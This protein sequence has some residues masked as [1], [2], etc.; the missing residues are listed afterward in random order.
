M[1]SARAFSLAREARRQFRSK[2]VRIW[3]NKC[4]NIK[5]SEILPIDSA[6]RSAAKNGK[7]NIGARGESRILM[8]FLT[9]FCLPAV[10]LAQAGVVRAPH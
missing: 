7:F 9:R 6:A 8:S 2:K 1:G 3:S 10:A 5:L 4:T